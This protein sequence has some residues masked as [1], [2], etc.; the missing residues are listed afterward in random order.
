MIVWR[1]YEPRD[2]ED[3]ARL[4]SELEAKVGPFD[5]PALDA[6]PILIGIVGETDGKVT[7]AIALEAEAEILLIGADPF[8]P[9]QM[10]PAEK[11]MQDV[12]EK[13]RIK[14]TRAFIPAIALE[15]TNKRGSPVERILKHF[16][17]RR[18]GL[19]PFTRGT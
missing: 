17:F 16:G 15:S 4:K 12:L 2:A 11:M 8:P 13:Y 5:L 19:T 14:L 9:K 10:A 7:H 3:V 18:E 1:I 6:R